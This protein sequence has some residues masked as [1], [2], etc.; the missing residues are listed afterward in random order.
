[1]IC[2]ASHSR[3]RMSGHLKPHQSPSTVPN[4]EEGEQSIKGHRRDHTQIDSRNGL[5]VIAKKGPP[6]LR[7]R[8]ATARHVFRD[9][10]LSHLEAQHQQ[11]AVNPGCTPQW[12]FPAHPPDQ[13]MQASVNAR[14]PYPPPRLPAPISFE[15]CAMPAQEGLRLHHLDNV[16]K[17]RPEPDQPHQQRAIDPPQTQARRG[18]YRRKAMLS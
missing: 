18:R 4:D 17:V 13:V 7:R 2:R 15:T 12:V 16:T 6:A 5:G 8:P 10:R 3:R 14:P 11:L 9:R 1:M